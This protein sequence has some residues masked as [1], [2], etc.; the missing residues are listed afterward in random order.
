[1]RLIGLL[2][3]PCKFLRI[4][5]KALKAAV[6]GSLLDL[7]D[8]MKWEAILLQGIP[9]IPMVN[10]VKV[11]CPELVAFAS[12]KTL[13]K[14]PKSFFSGHASDGRKFCFNSI[15]DDRRAASLLLSAPLSGKVGRRRTETLEQQRLT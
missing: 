10:R 12:L 15:N 1:V 13:L 14:V 2:Y 7:V 6:R 8:K 9:P 4:C 11:R 5:S 3:V